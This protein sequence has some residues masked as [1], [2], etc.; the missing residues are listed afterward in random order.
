VLGI[1]RSSESGL[2]TELGQLGNLITVQP[3]S[4]ISGQQAELPV[5]SEGMASRIAPVTGVACIASLSS[6]YVYRNPFIPAVQTSGI[7]LTAADPALKAT[8]GLT[9]AYGA[10][11]NNATARY[12]AVVLGSEAASLLAI[13][14]LARPA[15]VWIGGYWFTV[16]G[17]LAPV[18]AAS[19][20]GS[21]TDAMAFIGFPTAEQYFACSWAWR[22]GP[23]RRRRRDRQRYGHLRPRTPHRDRPAPPWAPPG[24]AS[25]SSRPTEDSVRPDPAPGPQPP[26]LASHHHARARMTSVQHRR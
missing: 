8:L 3:G 24:H 14:S 5:T 1:S 23:A 17:I 13:H 10:F 20:L 2:L 12:P 4:N 19:V 21:Q 22:R 9:V 26:G 11:L 25:R 6:T 16:T 15:Q 18:P 7:A